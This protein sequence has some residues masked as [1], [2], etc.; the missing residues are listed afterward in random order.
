MER[1]P[2]F[3]AE[4]LD[5]V[6]GWIQWP[7]LNK[8]CMSVYIDNRIPHFYFNEYF[9]LYGSVF[10]IGRKIPGLNHYI[11]FKNIFI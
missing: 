11:D 5:G 4:L 2:S 3:Q 1:H 7:V 8:I 9:R 10:V 6:W